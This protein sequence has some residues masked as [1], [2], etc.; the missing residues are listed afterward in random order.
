[1]AKK[2]EESEK[3]KAHSS[4]EVYLIYVFRAIEK[5]LPALKGKTKYGWLP[6]FG[7]CLLV[8]LALTGIGVY[9]DGYYIHPPAQYEGI[10]ASPAEILHGN[11]VSTTVT[12]VS[13]GNTVKTTTI[14]QQ[15]G[16]IL[17]STRGH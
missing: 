15:A 10:C 14:T 12:T 9:I 7:L 17:N 5:V 11:C 13:V 2:A 16:Q 8:L 6:A 3:D 4:Y 1:M